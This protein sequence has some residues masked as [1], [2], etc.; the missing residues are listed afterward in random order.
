MLEMCIPY[1][2]TKRLDDDAS[3]VDASRVS[4]SLSLQE[5]GSVVLNKMEWNRCAG[6]WGAVLS[7]VRNTKKIVLGQLVRVWQWL[8]STKLVTTVC[9]LHYDTKSEQS[10]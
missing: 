1:T 10:D 9:P 8:L 2:D 3:H 6:D 4:L 7:K 5:S